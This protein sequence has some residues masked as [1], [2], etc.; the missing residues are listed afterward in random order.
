MSMT[1]KEFLSHSGIQRRTLDFWLEQEWLVPERT[2]SGLRF[3][4]IDIA[5]ARFIQELKSDFGANDEGIDVI[6][7][8]VDQL[9]GLRRVLERLRM[10]MPRSD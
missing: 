5:R 2:R 9:H 3:T 7:H 6:L 4:D 10:N 8:L 1:E